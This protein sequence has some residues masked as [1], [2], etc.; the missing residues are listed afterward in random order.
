MNK[1]EN[2]IERNLLVG[3]KSNKKKKFRKGGNLLPDHWSGK[4]LC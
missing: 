3:R 4:K 1:K 2:P